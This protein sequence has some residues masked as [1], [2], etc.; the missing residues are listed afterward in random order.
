MVPIMKRLF[1]ENIAAFRRLVIKPNFLNRDVSIRSL[2]TTF[3]GTPVSFPVGVA[4]T[5][6]Q[7]LAHPDGEA[8]TAR[9]E[10]R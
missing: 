6:L 4:P 7:K 2:D 1:R 5:A 10:K 8:A 3:L 9:G